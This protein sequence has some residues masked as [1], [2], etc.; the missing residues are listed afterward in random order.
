MLYSIFNFCVSPILCL[1]AYLLA[2]FSLIFIVKRLKSSEE[3]P[4]SEKYGLEI[5]FGKSKVRTIIVSLI[6]VFIILF[7]NKYFVKS[8]GC[9]DIRIM[10]D[11]IYC[12]YVLATN[13]N[14]D[15]YTLPAKIEKSHETYGDETDE[16]TRIYY[17]IHNVYFDNGG[18][19]Y[20]DSPDYFSY[21]SYTTE[22]DQNGNEW[23]IELT[24][25]KTVHHSVEENVDMGIGWIV[26][27]VLS[28]LAVLISCV[29]CLYYHE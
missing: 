3:D 17:T 18:Y 1:W 29:F 27:S 4:R 8:L 13:E 22:Y 15:T 28:S 19:L 16:R 23:K 24:N 10:S 26:F 21:G 20:F 5:F 14:N 9:N 12:Y 6:C 2:V 11:G 25:N 7:S